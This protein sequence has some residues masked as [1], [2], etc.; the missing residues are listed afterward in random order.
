M[1]LF[2]DLDGFGADTPRVSQRL[3]DLRSAL[4]HHVEDENQSVPAKNVSDTLL[5]ATWNLQAFDGG[6]P[7]SRTDESYWYIAEIVSHF[8]LV[9]IQ[10]VGADLGALD[11]LRDRLGKTWKYIVS[12]V[13]EGTAGNDE[14]LAFLFDD[15]KVQFGG[16]AGEIVIPPGSNLLQS[17]KPLHIFTRGKRNSQFCR[18]LLRAQ[19]RR[20]PDHYCKQ[21]G[22][23]QDFRTHHNYSGCPE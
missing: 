16:V 18:I 21:R 17:G 14:R 19:D 20:F 9:A 15:R 11:R 23:I 22:R 10:E 2:Y 5:L 8:D 3:I 13:T 1:P 4:Q 7:D 6:K 12:D